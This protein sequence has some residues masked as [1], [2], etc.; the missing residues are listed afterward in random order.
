VKGARDSERREEHEIENDI[1]DSN[2]WWGERNPTHLIPMGM[3]LKITPRRDDDEREQSGGDYCEEADAFHGGGR[4]E[5][6]S[7]AKG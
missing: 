2:R 3:P 6:N 4:F 5:K 1:A 7:M